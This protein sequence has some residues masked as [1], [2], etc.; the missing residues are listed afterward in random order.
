[1][2]ERH[3]KIQKTEDPQTKAD[4]RMVGEGGLGAETYYDGNEQPNLPIHKTLNRLVADQTVLYMKIH[5]YHWYVQGPH[6]FTLHVKFEELYDESNEYFDAFA[7]RLIAKGEKPFSTLG[8]YLEHASIT[9]KPYHKKLS[10][11]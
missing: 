7:E 1:M 2:Q 3:I 4:S 10:A 11:V 8:E 6:F 5:Q 9:E